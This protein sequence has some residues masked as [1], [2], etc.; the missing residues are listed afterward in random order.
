MFFRSFFAL[1]LEMHVRGITSKKTEADRGT[2][3]GQLRLFE[4]M[5]M[6][7][8]SPAHKS[9]MRGYHFMC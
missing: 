3:L 5:G 9:E 8:L 6:C 7:V 4:Y 2:I 1:R